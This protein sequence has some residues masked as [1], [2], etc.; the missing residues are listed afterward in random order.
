[1]FKTFAHNFS[2]NVKKI[3][4]MTKVVHNVPISFQYSLLS[5][6]FNPVFI[7]VLFFYI[8]SESMSLGFFLFSYWKSDY[9]QSRNHCFSY[10]FMQECNGILL[11]L[12]LQSRLSVLNLSLQSKL[13]CFKSLFAV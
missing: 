2:L 9:L 3:V 10:L 13:S 5:C 8:S 4:P 11:N 12:S 6:F 1:M 7:N